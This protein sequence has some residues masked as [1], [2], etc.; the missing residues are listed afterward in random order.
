MGLDMYL[1]KRQSEEIGYWRK[2]NRLHGLFEQMWRERHPDAQDD[3]NCVDMLLTM[4]DLDKVERAIKDKLLPKTSGF[5][6]GQDSYDYYDKEMQ[7]T[8]LEIIKQA[9]EATENGY[10]IV[11]SCW[12]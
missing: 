7:K 1:H 9:K 4:T 10:D 5:F 2:H 6:F 3:F 8:D 11:Y 12:W